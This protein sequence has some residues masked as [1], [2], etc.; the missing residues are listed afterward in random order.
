MIGNNLMTKKIR[1][2]CPVLPH[3]MSTTNTSSHCCLLVSWGLTWGRCVSVCGDCWLPLS[4]HSVRQPKVTIRH[5]FIFT[6]TVWCNFG[7]PT[8]SHPLDVVT[9]VSDNDIIFIQ[10]VQVIHFISCQ[11]MYT[12]NVSPKLIVH[13]RQISMPN[14]PMP[15]LLLGFYILKKGTCCFDMHSDW[16][17]PCRALIMK[18]SFD[19]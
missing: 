8:H 14:I 9:Y 10:S 1:C 4:Y 6:R 12:V 18:K 5:P 19:L 11:N 3:A 13:C 2:D 16:S 17:F 15:I 7:I